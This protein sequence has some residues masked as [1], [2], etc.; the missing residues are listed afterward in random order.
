MST[1][2]SQQLD[3][4]VQHTVPS[5]VRY[6]VRLSRCQR[7]EWPYPCDTCKSSALGFGLGVTRQYQRLAKVFLVTFVS[8][9]T[10][11]PETCGR[12]EPIVLGGSL[13]DSRASRTRS[14]TF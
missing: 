9:S 14:Y 5:T 7:L 6:T 2:R 11:Y 1:L 4:F 12:Q 10:F 3:D 13:R 8:C